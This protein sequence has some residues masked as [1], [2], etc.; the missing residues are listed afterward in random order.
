MQRTAHQVHGSASVRACKL[1]RTL[2]PK[3]TFEK[4]STARLLK[5]LAG[6]QWA[7]AHIHS[8]RAHFTKAYKWRTC[9]CRCSVVRCCVTWMGLKEQR[10]G[11]FFT[12][13][14]KAT[15]QAAF[16]NYVTCF[17]RVDLKQS[18]RK[19]SAAIR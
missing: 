15:K 19:F 17:T 10:E 13:H 1:T 3:D 18:G 14:C 5:Q 12:Y 4:S 8:K 9:P 6:G 11:F 16:V 7:Q 2:D